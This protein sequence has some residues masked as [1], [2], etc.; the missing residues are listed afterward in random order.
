MEVDAGSEDLG[1]ESI[2]QYCREERREC[3]ES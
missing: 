3:S 1:W 2:V